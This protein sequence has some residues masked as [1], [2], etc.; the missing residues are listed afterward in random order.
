MLTSTDTVWRGIPTGADALFFPDILF[1]D[2]GAE[3][4][5]GLRIIGGDG[6]GGPMR[7]VLM[8]FNGVVSV[9]GYSE[10]AYW[11][12][13]DAI[14][15]PQHFLNVIETSPEP[16]RMAELGRFNL[17]HYLLCGGNMCCEVLAGDR[18]DVRAFET[19]GGLEEEALR[20]RTQVL[21]HLPG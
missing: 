11:S 16:A 3:G 4:A 17:T 7:G 6:A 18:Y 13:A 21:A 5:L 9:C 10:T 8:E 14:H 1:S 15:R 20:R 12:F 19:H 2:G